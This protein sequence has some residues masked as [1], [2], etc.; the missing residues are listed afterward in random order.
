MS[1]SNEP[2][3]KTPEPA[4]ESR[5]W[6]VVAFGAI[7]AGAAWG[8]WI[9]RAALG[10]VD[11]PFH[12]LQ[13]AHFLQGKLSINVV[14]GKDYG[15]L[16]MIP[17][18]HAVVAVLCKIVGAQMPDAVRW[19]SFLLSLLSLIPAWLLARRFAPNT[20]PLRTAQF[21][22]LPV[23]YPFFF[24]IYSDVFAMMV[25][26]LALLACVRGRHVV[27]G[28]VSALGVLTR[29]SQV[30]FAPVLFV[31]TMLEHIRNGGTLATFLRSP[32]RWWPFVLAPL[33]L[34]V[35]YFL[36]NRRLTFSGPD[37]DVPHLNV[38]NLLC[39][40]TTVG[41]LF[42][43]TAVARWSEI[44][45]YILRRPLVAMGLALACLLAA[46]TWIPGDDRNYIAVSPFLLRNHL[47]AW[48][49]GDPVNRTVMGLVA[50]FGALLVLAP[51]RTEADASTTMA[52][53]GAHPRSLAD[54]PLPLALLWLMSLVSVELVEPRYH[55]PA[56]VFFLL[57]R[58][59]TRPL[60]EFVQLG[61]LALPAILLH[62]SHCRTDWFL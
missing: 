29:Q 5:V 57:T 31:I 17:G 54:H 48:L 19:I 40:L 35:F 23:L 62:Y 55:L 44:G 16:A 38:G 61:W 45:A 22:F 9:V 20:A 13:I 46:W 15:F 36:N 32:R 12:Y 56:L 4:F 8:A 30:V 24:I 18:Y 3:T 42:F 50:V 26:L 41:T 33:T 1:D 37:Q 34:I 49:L 14:P 2:T 11:E 47:I 21:F 28:V 6:G 43:P 39:A 60:T 7:L 25:L 53:A 10:R 59:E 52:I 27:A 51:P 58:R